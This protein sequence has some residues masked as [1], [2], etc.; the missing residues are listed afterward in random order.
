MRCVTNWRKCMDRKS[1]ST[2]IQAIEKTI[3]ARS[4]T[5]LLPTVASVYSQYYKVYHLIW[6]RL[7]TDVYSSIAL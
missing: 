3:E 6:L 2:L 4:A 7:L 1:R 5:F